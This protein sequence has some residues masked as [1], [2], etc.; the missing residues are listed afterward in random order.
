MTNFELMLG[1]ASIV[2]LL[3]AYVAA[4]FLMVPH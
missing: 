3:A 4:Q 1:V 2:L